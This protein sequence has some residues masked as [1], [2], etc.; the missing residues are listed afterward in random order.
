MGHG[1]RDDAG[2]LA[3]AAAQ[4]AAAALHRKRLTR[5]RLTIAV[6]F[7]G[8]EEWVEEKAGAPA[9]ARGTQEVC[10]GRR[11]PALKTTSCRPATYAKMVQLNPCSTSSTRGATAVSYRRA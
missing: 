8:V 10:P 6:G 5:P 9:R 4:A 1:A 7:K 3:Q 2:R 11:R